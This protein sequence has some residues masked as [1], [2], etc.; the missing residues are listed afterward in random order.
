MPASGRQVVP[1]HSVKWILDAPAHAEVAGIIPQPGRASSMSGTVCAPRHLMRNDARRRSGHACCRCW[2]AR[3][4][5]LWVG[6]GDRR[7]VGTRAAA[8]GHRSTHRRLRRPSHHGNRQ[9][10][11]ACRTD[12]LTRTHRCGRRRRPPPARL[13]VPHGYPCW[14]RGCSAN[15]SKN[16]TWCT[17]D[18]ERPPIS[19]TQVTQPVPSTTIANA[20]IVAV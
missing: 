12:R 3:R 9:R 1:G 5:R 13:A 2:R 11:H 17:S 6:R 16:A 20:T 10:R 14:Q 7:L 18:N 19:E 8:T 4:P 15:A